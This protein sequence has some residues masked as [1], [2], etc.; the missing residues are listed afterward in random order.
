MPL[1]IGIHDISI[2]DYLADPCE[3]PSL[4]SG[5]VN[6]L[7]PDVSTPAEFKALH[8]RLTDFPEYAQKKAT[9]EME[10][11]SVVHC[12]ILGSG[13]QFCVLDPADF[14]TKDGK[15]SKTFGSTAAAAAKA[16]AESKGLIVM[17]PEQMKN[18]ET[19]AQ[20]GAVR[21]ATL[22]GS[23]P[24]G[25]VERTFIWQEESGYGP[26]WCMA[27]PD[28]WIGEQA[29]LVELKVPSGGLSDD[30][31]D[32]FLGADHGRTIIQAAWQRRGA[33]KLFPE[34]AGRIRH[35]LV[36]LDPEPPYGG[37]RIWLTEAAL[38]RADRR[39][40]KAVRTFGW[41]LGNGEWPE[42]EDG[43]LSGPSWLESA[44]EA[45]EAEEDQ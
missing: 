12:L 22:F 36:F 14:P 2:A 29:T 37:R 13:A 42:W 8:P 16:D 23:W 20:L 44:W 28:V 43:L 6:L 38:T 17:T 4:R 27:R 25:E 34:L 35:A 9:K 32:R 24:I 15:P 5:G 26:V 45:A 11:G 30:D 39:C 7:L 31:I 40:D 3:G 21:L 18:A 10:R 41:C 19:I 1:G 33:A